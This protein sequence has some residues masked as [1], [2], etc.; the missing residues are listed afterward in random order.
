[1][2]TEKPATEEGKKPPVEESARRRFLSLVISVLGAAIGVQKRSYLEKDFSQSSP[3]PYIVAG[4]V[5][6]FLFMLTLILV[7]K[8]VLA[9]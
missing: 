1:M 2:T 5:F 6:T 3:L 8:L 7:V 9:E 4:V